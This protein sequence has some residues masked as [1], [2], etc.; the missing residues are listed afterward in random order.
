MY[1]SINTRLHEQI[2]LEASRKEH[3]FEDIDN[4]II[5]SVSPVFFVWILL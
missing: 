1:E 2:D 4:Y 5:L 3:E